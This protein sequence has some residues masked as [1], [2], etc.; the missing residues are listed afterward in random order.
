MVGLKISRSA[1][2]SAQD[3]NRGRDLNIT[4][5]ARKPLPPSNKPNHDFASTKSTQIWHEY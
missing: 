1:L 5:L 3:S 4:V 2:G